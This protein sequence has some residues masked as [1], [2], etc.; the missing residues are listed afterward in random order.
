MR[1]DSGDNGRPGRIMMLAT[2][3][4]ICL[5]LLLNQLTTRNM[6]TPTQDKQM[7]GVGETLEERFGAGLSWQMDLAVSDGNFQVSLKG[8]EG[9]PVQEGTVSLVIF[10]QGGEKVSEQ[11]LEKKGPGR[12]AG[13]LPILES[14]RFQAKVEA[15]SPQGRIMRAFIIQF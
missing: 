2:I 7:F 13:P 12:F 10:G 8:D 11:R 14:G 15:V 5:V 3:F 4:L 1:I 6:P 9:Y